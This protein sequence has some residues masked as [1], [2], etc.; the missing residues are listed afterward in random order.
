M[1]DL[2]FATSACA[3]LL[4]LLAALPSTGH[5]A[6]TAE[7]QRLY[8]MHCIAC[9][10]ATGESL[11]PNTPNFSRGE[12]L[13]QADIGIMASIKAGKNAMPAFAGVL[14]DQQILDVIAYLRTFQR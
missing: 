13:M 2:L 7:G 4:G 6:D 9:H 10:G 5:A 8:Q 11:I 12:G 14:R 1:R 3:G